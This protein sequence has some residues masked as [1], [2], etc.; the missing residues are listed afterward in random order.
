[1]HLTFCSV[2]P[3]K[4]QPSG[5][6][7]ICDLYGWPSLPPGCRTPD[8]PRNCPWLLYSQV[9]CLSSQAPLVSLLKLEINLS[10][11]WCACESSKQL[12]LLPGLFHSR[13]SGLI[14]RHTIHPS[15]H[16]LL[17]T[18]V[19]SSIDHYRHFHTMW[20]DLFIFLGGSCV[21]Q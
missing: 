6:G 9:F 11:A 13:V 12:T 4:L 16:S 21:A 17:D 19:I 3:D 8:D 1:M 2:Q 18:V 14:N 10:S 5:F 15:T 20:M 7:Q